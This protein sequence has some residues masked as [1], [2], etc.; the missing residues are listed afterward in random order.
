MSTILQAMPISRKVTVVILLNCITALVIAGTA[1]FAVQ[2]ITFRRSLVGEL[3]AVTAIIANNASLPVTGNDRRRALE[4]LRALEAKPA[5]T[6]ASIRLNNGSIFVRYG[7]TPSAE[8]AE[9]TSKVKGVEFTG[10]ELVIMQPILDEGRQI[11]MLQVRAAYYRELHRLTILYGEILVGVLTVA[12]LL[13]FLFS[14]RLRRSISDPILELA[15][16]ARVVAERNDY[17]VR[18]QKLEQ[19][20]LGIFTDSFNKML[21]Q[22]ETQDVALQAS[23]DEL[24]RKVMDRTLELSSSNRNLHRELEERQRAEKEA[25]EARIE[26][27]RANQAKS[28]FLS[29][30]SH[31]LR[32][33]MNAILGFGQLL[34]IDFEAREM[35]GA[36]CPP[37]FAQERHSVDQILKGGAHLLE[38]MNEILDLSAIEAGRLAVSCESVRLADVV[39]ESI[40]LMQPL[41]REREIALINK[42]DLGEAQFAFADRQRIKQVLLNLLSNAIKYN[43]DG[44]SVSIS[45]SRIAIS[46]GNAVPDSSSHFTRI[47]VADTGPGISTQDQQRLFQPFQRLAAERTEI[48]GTGLGLTLSRHMVEL[49]GG[50]LTVESTV[51]QGSTFSIELLSTE[52]PELD[53]GALDE[54]A[55]LSGEVADTALTILF[56]EDNL[57]NLHL[58]ERI[59]A[60]RPQMKIVPAMQGRIALQLAREHKPDLILL[61]PNLPDMHGREVLERFQSEPATRDLPIVIISA[62]TMGAQRDRLL[63][64]GAFAYL[65]KPLDVREFVETIRRALNTSPAAVS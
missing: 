48:E 13:A 50:T 24:E 40:E 10:N 65:S 41:A 38:L 63:A 6:Y 37:D 64:D 60:H 5:V 36:E 3:S 46:S 8:E 53:D 20:E 51:G 14:A 56:V 26:A 45:C 2:V 11:G 9:Q 23:R 17:S 31:E 57:S 33:P 62:D 39:L 42:W 28:E 30:M 21:A 4:I 32:T 18:A 29:R 54:Y 19:N 22:I 25:R 61:D 47:D 16:T 43:R 1:M 35:E 49:M 44:G 27:D 52:A 34:E 59:L 15:E 58:V 55:S 12:V 7:I